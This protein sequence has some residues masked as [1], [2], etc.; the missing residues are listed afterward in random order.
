MTETFN[1]SRYIE[2]LTKDKNLE[3]KNSSLDKLTE[4]EYSELLSYSIILYSQIVYNRKEEYLSLIEKYLTNE[5]NSLFLRFEF[6]H[7]QTTHDKMTKNFENNFELLSNVLIDP[8][9]E[10]FTRLLEDIAAACEALKSDD[11]PD[12]NYG[13]NELQFRAFLE[14]TFLQMKK[15][16]DQ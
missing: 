6:F 15:Y 10:E 7:L 3:S 16:L 1:K 14:K 4:L 9:S 5:I 8:K 13:I 12:Q 2:L 11:E